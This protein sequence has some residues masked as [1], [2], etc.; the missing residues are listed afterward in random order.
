MD[1]LNVYSLANAMLMVMSAAFLA[2][3]PAIWRR[4]VSA[5]ANARSKF[6]D[7]GV[8]VGSVI[9][10]GSVTAP[11]NQRPGPVTSSRS[12]IR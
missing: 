2:V 9:G 6:Q 11:Y 12:A 8:G 3:K 10:F 4:F 5:D 7:W 1:V